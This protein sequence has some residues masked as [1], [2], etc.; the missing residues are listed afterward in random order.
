[1]PNGSESG[2]AIHGSTAELFLNA[3]KLVVLGKSVHAGKRAGLDLSGIGCHGKVCNE[4]IF[5]F[6]AAVRNHS[7]IAVNHCQSHGLKGLG[8]RANLVKLH[9]NGIG[10]P[11]ADSLAEEIHIGHKEVIAHQLAAVT[12]GVREQL[13]TLPVIFGA[14]VLDGDDGIA[15]DKALVVI[16]QLSGGKAVARTLFE[17]VAVAF[18]VIEL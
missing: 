13:P 5:R 14:T 16:R 17:N 1:M 6:A 11:G 2:N 12:N 15:A 10:Y 9:Q 3:Q 4:S 18:R 7:R 8:E